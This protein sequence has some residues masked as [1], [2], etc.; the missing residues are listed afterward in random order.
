MIAERVA[1]ELIGC[2]WVGIPFG[3]S[4]PEVAR[5]EAQ[6]IVVSDLHRHVINLA[7]TIRS[8]RVWLLQRLLRDSPFHP[9]LLQTAQDFCKKNEPRLAQAT[10]FYC[11]ADAAYWYFISQWMG[12]SG[13]AGTDGEFNG[14]IAT[15]W[16]AN[17][18][19]SNQRY[20]AAVK[21]LGAWHRIMQRC[22]FEVKGCFE[23]LERCE[24]T[25]KVGIYCDPPF[26]SDAPGNKG[27]RYRHK[28]SVQQHADLARALS[29]FKQA[30]VVCR[31]YGDHPLI[32]SL[33]PRCRGGDCAGDCWYWREIKGGRTQA[34]KVA[35]EVLIM[36]GP[37][38]A[39]R[40]RAGLFDVAF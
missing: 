18:G 34:N 25:P 23:F 17:G 1:E 26:P 12:R 29:R 22:C 8:N 10:D 30:R 14:G 31:F 35:P 19:G 38:R 2:N 6:H 28:F 36:N 24:D 13:K 9:D 15:V 5:I 39:P 33:Y 11:D 3:G 21:S 16:N 32:H 37:S 7:L 27:D 20:R 40:D 4:M